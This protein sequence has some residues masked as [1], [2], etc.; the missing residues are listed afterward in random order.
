MTI[1][2]SNFGTTTLGGSS[3][4]PTEQTLPSTNLNSGNTG[5]DGYEDG[6][7]S[8][9]TSML[10][11]V[12]QLAT[13][14]EEMPS[15]TSDSLYWL[16]SWGSQSTNDVSNSDPAPEAEPSAYDGVPQN[17]PPSD[18]SPTP[19]TEGPPPSEDQT[20]GTAPPSKSSTYTPVEYDFTNTDV[21]PVSSLPYDDKTPGSTG[22][23]SPSPAPEPTPK[24]I[25]PD[26]A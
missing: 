21:I 17:P 19:P 22:A 16:V 13:A 11:A 3:T 5:S 26:D 9:L 24:P 10:A 6:G 18:T 15:E 20:P 25:G 7:A 4:G 23:P 12:E 2:P 8:T 14:A 1:T